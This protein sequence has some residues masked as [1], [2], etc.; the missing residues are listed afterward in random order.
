[1]AAFWRA[2]P[3]RVQFGKACFGSRA[4]NRHRMYIVTEGREAMILD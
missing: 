4:V 3:V 2:P 1:M